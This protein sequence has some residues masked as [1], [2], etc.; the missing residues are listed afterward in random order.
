MTDN[1]PSAADFPVR[2]ARWDGPGRPFTVVDTVT[3]GPGPGEV[4]VRID[5]A[6]VCG[7]DVH[8]V[9]GRRGSPA[10]GVL[11]HEQVGTVLAAGGEVRCEDGTPVVPGLRVVWSVAASCGTCDRC[12]RGLTQKCR[13]LF[14]YGHQEL[15][16]L[17]PLTGGF[18]THCV[19]R[20]GTAVVAVPDGLPDEVAAPAACATATVAAV[21]A[22]A[23]ELAGRRVLV[24]GAGMLG[25]T[26]VAMAAE[27]GARV[28]AADPDPYR[29]EQALRFGAAEVHTTGATEADVALELSGHPDAVRTCLHSLTTGGT[30]VL[31]GSVFPGP[32]VAFD[33]E[34]LVRGLHKVVGVHNYRPADLKRAVDFLAAHHTTYPFAELVEGDYDLGTLDAAFA[35][36][37]GA[38]APRQAVRPRAAAVG[39]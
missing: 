9:T 4:L 18:A 19:L 2:Y 6:T 38:G 10:P 28:T 16:E 25:V 7:S 22:E 12:A 14:K 17:A 11:G 36:A 27:A 8:T 31:A 33:P 5:L 13:A 3:A 21:L 35:G 26:A 39:S 20:P 34:R 23:G 37:R 29:R 15:D 1:P 24:T 30:A 32:A